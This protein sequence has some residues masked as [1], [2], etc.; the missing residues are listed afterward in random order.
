M[1]PFEKSIYNN[2]FP[3]IAAERGVTIPSYDEAVYNGSM[4]LLNSHP[5][6]GSPFRLPQN[7]KYV[8]GYHIDKQVPPMPKVRF[9]GSIFYL[10]FF[11]TTGLQI[12]P[13]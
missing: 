4:L 6:M 11:Y 2:V 7:A 3:K 12:S 8:A 10:F 1:T 9:A 13:R 5:S